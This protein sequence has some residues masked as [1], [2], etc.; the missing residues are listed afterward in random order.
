MLNY[1]DSEATPQLNNNLNLNQ[2]IGEYKHKHP[3]GLAPTEPIFHHG[4]P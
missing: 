2:H 1:P 4:Q 3:P